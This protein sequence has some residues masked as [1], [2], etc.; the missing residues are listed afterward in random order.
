MS[1]HSLRAE[2]AAGPVSCFSLV[3]VADPGVMSRVLQVFAKR[4]LMPSRWYSTV[5]GAAGEEL[6]IDLQVAGLD[7]ALKE[8][9]AEAL[10]GLVGVRAVLT[11]EKRRAATA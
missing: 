6:A 9:L 7:P 10:R 1:P 8:R 11:S 5:A 2:H 3:A 4:G